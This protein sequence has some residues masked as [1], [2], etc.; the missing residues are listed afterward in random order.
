MSK[1]Q[2]DTIAAGLCGIAL[3]AMAISLSG[4]ELL[5]GGSSWSGGESID[6]TSV[7]DDDAAPSDDSFDGDDANQDDDGSQDDLWSPGDSC[8]GIDFVERVVLD[9]WG[10]PLPTA[11]GWL[12]PRPAADGPLSLTYAATD[13]LPTTL[14]GA[15][16]DGHYA[17]VAVS[18]TAAWTLSRDQRPLPDWNGLCQVETLYI[19]LDHAWFSGTAARP[20]RDG[21]LVDLH[22][23]GQDFWIDVAADLQQAEETVTWATWWWESDFEL[24]R[25]TGHHT[26]TEQQRLPNT[27]LAMLEA[28]PQVDKRILVSRWCG[29]DCFDLLDWVTIDD[30]LIEHAETDDDFEVAMQDNETPVPLLDEFE[31]EAIE[32]DF[33]ARVATQAIWGG[34]DFGAWGDDEAR[35]V[36]AASYHQKM[37]TI[38]GEVAYVTGMNVRSVDWD[39]TE[40]HVFDERRMAF[41]ATAEDR[42]EVLDGMA[43]TD[44]NPRRDYGVRVEGPAV[45]DV[46]MLLRQR[47]AETIVED[48]PYAAGNTMWA[49][50][51]TAAARPSGVT[52]QFQVTMPDPIPER[53]ILESM[54][55]AIAQADRYI[56][57]EDQYWRAPLLNEVLLETLQSKPWVKLIVVTQPVAL[58][59]PG[60]HWTAQTDQLFRNEVPDQYLTLQLRTFDW[61]VDEDWIGDDE[62]DV[63]DLPVNVHSKLMIVDDRYLSVGSANKNNRGLLFE[64]EANMAV[65]DSDW[66]QQRR[67]EI[68]DDILGPDFGSMMDDGPFDEALWNLLH[69]A[70]DWNADVVA[71]WADNHNMT[72]A[73]AAAEEASGLWPSGLVH[74][75]ELPEYGLIEFGPDTF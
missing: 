52:A 62:I 66:V 68:F 6:M 74:P 32:V 20:P 75:L 13:H 35:E 63:H 14:T 34:R 21:N 71:W 4:C 19:G 7:D 38:D 36:P 47:W 65:L 50:T 46:D 25:P 45:A 73:Q 27:V 10:Q 29:D 39:T 22:R 56:Y 42:L 44:N 51:P 1:F 64:G 26:M 69:Q 17:D 18:G 16:I 33:T 15:I 11:Q 2:P 49:P 67:I 59:D 37:L 70:A 57:I 43:M 54:A 12:Q 58:Y 61:G 5:G 30:P 40:H 8:E 9:I 31:Y 28:M 3:I 55:K 60:A 48:E 41:D 53:S 23:S 72:P 24:L